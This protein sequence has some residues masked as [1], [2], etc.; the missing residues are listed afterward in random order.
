MQDVIK[1]AQS[2]VLLELKVYVMDRLRKIETD[3]DFKPDNASEYA[4]AQNE[5]I[6]IDDFLNARIYG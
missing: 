4:L 5:L 3:P 2:A 6:C 1:V